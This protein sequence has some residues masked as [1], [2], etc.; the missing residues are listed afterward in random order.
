VSLAPPNGGPQMALP[1]VTATSC[2]TDRPTLWAVD[3]IRDAK[4]SLTAIE[5]KLIQ[6]VM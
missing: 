1:F 2:D 6:R 3:G 4:K 5:D